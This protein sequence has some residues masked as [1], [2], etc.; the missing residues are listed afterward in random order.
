MCLV[1]SRG[2]RAFSLMYKLGFFPNVGIEPRIF[3]VLSL[4]APRV[5]AKVLNKLERVGKRKPLCFC[6]KDIAPPSYYPALQLL[7]G[8]TSTPTSAEAPRSRPRFDEPAL[9]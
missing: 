1:G 7:A 4:S 3:S 2:A 5:L 8:S 9:R 6:L